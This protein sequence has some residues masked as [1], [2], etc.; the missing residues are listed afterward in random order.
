MAP[1]SSSICPNVNHFALM[2]LQCV[3]NI[4][5]PAIG[6][7]YGV[8]INRNFSPGWADPEGS[9]S[10]PCSQAYHGPKPESEPETLTIMR[11]VQHLKPMVL[12]SFHSYSQLWMYPYGYKTDPAPNQGLLDY[13]STLATTAIRKRHGKRYRQGP[14]S[15]TICKSPS[16]QNQ[17]YM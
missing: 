8:D 6:N 4:P 12:F 2:S 15:T 5:G 16:A 1:F 11:A 7:T 13:L 14:I 9:S 3:L 10:D 17:T